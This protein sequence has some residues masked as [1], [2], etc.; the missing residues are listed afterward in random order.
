MTGLIGSETQVV[1]FSTTTLKATTHVM[2]TIKTKVGMAEILF[3][4]RLRDT[5]K[6]LELAS[7]RETSCLS[8]VRSRHTFGI[9][10]RME[11]SLSQIEFIRFWTGFRDL[12]GM[13]MKQL[14]P[15]LDP[16][17]WLSTSMNQ[18]TQGTG[19]DLMTRV[20]NWIGRCIWTWVYIAF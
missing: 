20:E 8:M 16:I 19:S 13:G 11:I 12:S 7:G 9:M 1:R 2:L 3:G 17:S 18:T 6:F 4:I 14:R 10:T 15:S 5:V